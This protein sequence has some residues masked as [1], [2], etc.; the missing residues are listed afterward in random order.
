MNY[1]GT[2]LQRNGDFLEILTFLLSNN[3]REMC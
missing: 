2:D 3:Q 1:R